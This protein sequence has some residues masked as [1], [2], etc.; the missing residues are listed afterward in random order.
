M[1]KVPGPSLAAHP[2]AFTI[3]VRR[4]FW[5]A[6]LLT[7]LYTEIL[8]EP[9]FPQGQTARQRPQILFPKLCLTFDK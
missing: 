7:H 5:S 8:L 4:I 6:I 3:C 1:A 9:Y 2:A